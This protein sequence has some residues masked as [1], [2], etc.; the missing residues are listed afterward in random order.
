MTDLVSE[1]SI[2]LAVEIIT[3]EA[4]YTLEPD[5]TAKQALVVAATLVKTLVARMVDEHGHDPDEMNAWVRASA[6]T[7][8]GLDVDP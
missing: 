8:L 4:D 2:Q 6:Y 3:G 1:A 7:L 5:A